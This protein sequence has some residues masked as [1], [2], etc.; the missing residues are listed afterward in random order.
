LQ[1]APF[2]S[3]MDLVNCCGEQGLLSVA[4]DPDYETNGA[5]YVNYTGYAGMG[6]TVVARYIVA[7]PASD[8]ASVVSAT[9]V[10]TVVQPQANHNG[11]QLQFGP[12]DDVLYI[13]MGDGGAAG[14]Q[15]SGHHEPGGNAQWPGTLLGKMLRI[16]VRGALTYTIPPPNPFT[17]TADY[18][19]EIWALGL[20]NPWRFSFDRA[21]GDMYT[22]DVGQYSWEEV[23]YQPASS[24][25]GENYGWRVLEG[26]HCFNPSTDCD[27]SGKV[28]PI[29]E[30]SH[31]L[32]CSVTGGYVYRGSVYPWLNGVYFY[33]DYCSGRIW[34]L[35]QVS[36]GVWSS[37]EK[38]NE[39]FSISSFG[40]DEDGELYVLDYSDGRVLR[41]TVNGYRIHLP[42]IYKSD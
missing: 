27:A 5:L 25:G 17:Q 23:S 8:V 6:D 24:P 33:A 37:V 39:N 14:D 38:R 29:A 32:G 16:D 35:E 22:G 34:S 3:I 13:G 36:P 1:S 10:L 20:R 2:L 31:S 19:P 28:L 9:Q 7:D 42:V 12:H 4:F 18:R 26:T 30:Y 15:G 21:T 11:G 41:L 40:E